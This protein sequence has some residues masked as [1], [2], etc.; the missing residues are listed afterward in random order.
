MDAALLYSPD[1]TANHPSH[2]LPELRC[3]SLGCSSRLAWPKV[4]RIV[5]DKAEPEDWYCYIHRKEAKKS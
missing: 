3:S 4:R 5:E 2:K 1:V